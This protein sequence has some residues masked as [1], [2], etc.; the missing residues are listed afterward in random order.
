MSEVRNDNHSTRT[1]FKASMV[2]R[3]KSYTEKP[4]TETE[5]QRLILC[6]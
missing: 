2:Y 3:A 1:E 6:F 5:V 4:E